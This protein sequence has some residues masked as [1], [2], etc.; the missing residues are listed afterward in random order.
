MYDLCSTNDEK[1][2]Y[3][4][5]LSICASSGYDTWLPPQGHN[6]QPPASVRP[7]TPLLA[8]H[9]RPKVLVGNFPRDEQDDRRDDGRC[10]PVQGQGKWQREHLWELQRG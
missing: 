10:H 2:I 9:W 6:F 8:L 7:F 1:E 5:A 4:F 3:P